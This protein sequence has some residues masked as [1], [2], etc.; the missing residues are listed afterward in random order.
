MSAF[1]LYY[2]IAQSLATAK[3]YK[4]DENDMLTEEDLIAVWEWLN[5]LP[6]EEAEKL[7]EKYYAKAIKE[8]AAEG[9]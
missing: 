3:R 2:D 1:V 6:P 9:D 4:M 5:T 8:R 7:M